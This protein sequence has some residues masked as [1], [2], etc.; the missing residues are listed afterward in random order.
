VILDGIGLRSSLDSSLNAIHKHVEEFF[1][2]HLLQDISGVAI[3]VLES[4]AESLGVDVLLF[5]FE[6]S[7]KQ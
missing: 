1:N 2:V 7:S 5:R 3:P 4:V 6:K